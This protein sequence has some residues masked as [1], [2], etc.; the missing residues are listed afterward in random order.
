MTT[1]AVQPLAEPLSHDG[2]DVGVLVLHGFTG[3]PQTMRP[4]ADALVADGYTV[5][6]P[7]L[8]GHGTAV[9]DMLETTF[10]DWSA[11]VEAT[12]VDLA[13][14]VQCVV[15]VGLSMGGTLAAQLVAR[16]PEIVGAVLVNAL[17]VPFDPSLLTRFWGSSHRPSPNG[18]RPRSPRRPRPRS[19]AGR[20]SSPATTP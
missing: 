2:S 19:R 12:Y 13:A 17:V 11:H 15:V 3:S 16:H 9:E 5:E 18:S 4:V 14:R 20:T 10:D 6:L 7:R 8:P 1:Y